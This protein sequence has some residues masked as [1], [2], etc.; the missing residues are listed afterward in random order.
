M[1]ILVT[2]NNIVLKVQKLVNIADNNLFFI[3]LELLV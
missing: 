1:I 3:R 2:R